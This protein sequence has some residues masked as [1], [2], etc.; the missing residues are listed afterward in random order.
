MHDSGWVF[1]KGLSH[2]VSDE[3]RLPRKCQNKKALIK[4]I[5]QR[6]MRK[7]PIM[8]HDVKKLQGPGNEVMAST[9][10]GVGAVGGE[11]KAGVS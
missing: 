2:F 5:L 1:A 4:I 9:S 7:S 11:L 10:R 6:T 3:A 8:Y